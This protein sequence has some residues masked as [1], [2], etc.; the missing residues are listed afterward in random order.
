MEP[1]LR[2]VGPTLMVE[3]DDG[4]YQGR[5]DNGR[6]LQHLQLTFRLDRPLPIGSELKGATELLQRM[7]ADETFALDVVDY[8]EHALGK[9]G[10]EC[11]GR[12]VTKDELFTDVWPDTAVTDDVLV[13]VVKELRRTLGDDPHHP[14]FIK[15]VPKA[16]YRF[17]CEVNE[18]S[19]SI[20]EEITR[21]EFE[22]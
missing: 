3:Y 13:Q 7:Q 20:T 22:I 16:G 11:R 8:A 19:L 4:I 9:R 6:L 5:R 18:S 2:W 14:Q 21:V 12:L 17:I 10:G 15:T 1:V